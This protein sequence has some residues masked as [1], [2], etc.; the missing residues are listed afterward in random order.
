MA[1]SDAQI[2]TIRRYLWIE[3][4][5]FALLPTFAATMARGYGEVGL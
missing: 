2:R 1:P 3:F 4:T 5:L